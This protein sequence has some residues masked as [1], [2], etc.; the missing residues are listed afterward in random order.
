MIFYGVI[1]I[2]IMFSAKYLTTVIFSDIFLGG[3][4]EAMTTTD[5]INKL[6][7]N[8]VFPF[9]KIAIYLS[10]GFLVIMMM[11]RVFTYITAQDDGTKKKA[12]G[13]ITWTTI[14]MLF[15]IAAKQIVEA[16]YGKQETVLKT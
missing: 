13:V 15:I 12:L 11:I 6:Y 2:I 8:I 10:L 1:G 16:V 9:I 5:W 3:V 4:G 7:N 14:G